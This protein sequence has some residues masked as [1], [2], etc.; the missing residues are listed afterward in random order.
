MEPALFM[1]VFYYVFGVLRDAG[2]LEYVAFLL[3]GLIVWQ[4]LRSTIEHA[5]E[6]IR[7]S[8]FLMRQVHLPAVLPPLMVVSTDT[9]KFLL[10]LLVLLLVLVPL[11]YP[12]GTGLLWLP[13][14][15]LAGMLLVT[16][17]GLLCAVAIPF[18]PDIKHV[19]DS[20]LLLMMFV[21]GVFFS[22]SELP[23]EH[24]A[25]LMANPFAVLIESFRSALMASG[26]VSLRDLL[27][28]MGWGAALTALGVFMANRAQRGLP[29][30]AE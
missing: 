20:L 3:C 15:V 24:R 13:L 25:V 29:K 27:Y 9:T 26:A 21:S 2:G 17:I 12:P 22:P 23:P 7:N 6:S 14:L 11:G 18:V 19:V 16:G 10:V 28:V 1:V 30:L 8:L 4:W 5:A